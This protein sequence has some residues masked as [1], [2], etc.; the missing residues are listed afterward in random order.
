MF[1]MNFMPVF[2]DIRNNTFSL[3]VYSSGRKKDVL[4][5]T[6]LLEILEILNFFLTNLKKK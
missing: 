5:Q 3:L 2:D 6:T 4:K 1:S